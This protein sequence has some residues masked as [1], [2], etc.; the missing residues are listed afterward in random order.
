MLRAHFPGH[1]RYS[2]THR[3]VQRLREL[4]STMDDLDDEALRDR[5][6]EALANAEDSGKAVRTLDAMLGEPQVLIPV[7]TF[8]ETMFAIIKEDTVVTVLPKGHGEEILQRGQALEQRVANGEVVARNERETADRWDAG[9]RRRWRREAPGP[10]VIER[11]AGTRPTL[12]R[13][14]VDNGPVAGEI[15]GAAVVALDSR[16]RPEEPVAAALYDALERGRRQAAKAALSATLEN[17][18]P[19]ESLL[20]LWNELARSG[21]PQTLTVGDLLDAI[22]GDGELEL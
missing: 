21:V 13:A 16:R 18:D 6:D 11:G 22:R 3:A 5:L 2:I 10:V 7:D 8:G 20:P 15:D 14:A 1:R 9:P 17:V 19:D 12:A 4:V